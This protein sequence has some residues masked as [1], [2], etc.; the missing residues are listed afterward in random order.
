MKLPFIIL[1]IAV[2]LLLPSQSMAKEVKMGLKQFDQLMKPPA[3][4]VYVIKVYMAEAKLDM[5]KPCPPNTICDFCEPPYLTVSAG[6]KK[7]AI[8]DYVAIPLHTSPKGLKLDRERTYIIKLRAH[9]NSDKGDAL[10]D[11][12]LLEAELIP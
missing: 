7:Q 9:Y 5:C 10:P 4:N 1:L 12:D 3:D 8:E 6:E 2:S 11:Y